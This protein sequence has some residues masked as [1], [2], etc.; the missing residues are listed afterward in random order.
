MKQPR[1]IREGTG[2]LKIR[3]ELVKEQ[4][5]YRVFHCQLCGHQ[6]ESTVC[7]VLRA[8]GRCRRDCAPY[9][10]WAVESSGAIDKIID[11]YRGIIQDHH[12][13]SGL[14]WSV[15]EHAYP[16]GPNLCMHCGKTYQDA[17]RLRSHHDKKHRRFAGGIG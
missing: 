8:K 9:M 16:R 12:V 7:V 4:L 13:R 14:C 11:R 3:Q 6:K 15:A 5:P 2:K 17:G 10:K 1:K